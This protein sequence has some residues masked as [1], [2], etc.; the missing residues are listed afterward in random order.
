MSKLQLIAKQF[1]EDAFYLWVRD[2]VEDVKRFKELMRDISQYFED[3]RYG[4]DP[5][6][7]V[8][9]DDKSGVRD[10]IKRLR[11]FLA[12]VKEYTALKKENCTSI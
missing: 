1:D 3:G 5:S 6:K 11:N 7:A 4:Y 2:N 12:K 9:F 10:D 8:Y